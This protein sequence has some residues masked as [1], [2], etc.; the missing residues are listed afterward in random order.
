MGPFQSLSKLSMAFVV[1]FPWF[2]TERKLFCKRSGR[3]RV[4]QDGSCKQEKDA[5]ESQRRVDLLAGVMEEHDNGFFKPLTFW[6][7][8]FI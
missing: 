5:P 6:Q 8:I 4:G 2:F 1:Q 3:L 7:E